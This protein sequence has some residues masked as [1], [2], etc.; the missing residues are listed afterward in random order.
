TR[1]LA[2]ALSELEAANRHKSAFLAAMSHELRTPLN[3]IIGFAELLRDHR[4]GELN[5]R[6]AR[7]V[8]HIIT[9][10]RHLLSLINDILDLSKAERFTSVRGQ[11]RRP[12]RSRCWCAIRASG[13]RRRNRRASSSPLSRAIRAPNGR[14]KGPAWG[15]PW[16]DRWWSCMAAAS[17]SRANPARAA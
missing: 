10:G 16:R 3:A 7:Y 17:G 11:L 6:Q 13:S 4:V 1:D 15:S 12:T 5:E 8:G 2:R 9:S 14:E